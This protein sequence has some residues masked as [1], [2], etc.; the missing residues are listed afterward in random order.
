MQTNGLHGGGII[1]I[2]AVVEGLPTATE[3]TTEGTV[4]VRIVH[5]WSLVGHYREII[6]S[7]VE[8]REGGEGGEEEEV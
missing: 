2:G 3:A 6:V 7:G 5:H 8:G 1:G 4:A